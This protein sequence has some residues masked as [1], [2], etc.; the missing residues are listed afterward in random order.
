[1]FIQ[2]PQHRFYHIIQD[3]DMSILEYMFQ[4]S[5][6]DSKEQAALTDCT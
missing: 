4:Y 3:L 6:L 2:N 5:T 1:M